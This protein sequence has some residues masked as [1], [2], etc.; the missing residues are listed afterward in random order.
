MK[1]ANKKTN[2]AIIV[3]GDEILSG[4]TQ[5][6]NVSF[7]SRWLNELGVKVS[8]VRIIEDKEKSIVSCIQELKNKFKYVFTT[9]GIGPTHD[10]I[11]SKSVAKAFNLKY[12]FHKEAYDILEKYYKPGEFNKG[13]KKMAKIPEG[14]LLIYN[15][16]SGAPGF[17]VKNV[18]CLPGVPSILQS[19]VDGLKNKIIGG[20]KILSKTISIQ[21]VESEISISLENIQKRFKNVQI[22][23]YPFFRLGKIGVSIVVR[24]TDKKKID[25]CCKQIISFINK[26][27]IQIIKR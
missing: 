5:D 3:I 17:I 26:K 23:S 22:G 12:G 1:K 18:F 24:S 13:R 8:E 14:A 16:S 25:D 15:P 20:N 9:G 19:M 27:K 4:R 2:S 7:L 11:T 21:T 6:V 10:D